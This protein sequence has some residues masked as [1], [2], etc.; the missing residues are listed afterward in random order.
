MMALDLRHNDRFHALPTAIFWGAI[1]SEIYAKPETVAL[2][3]FR[4]AY[5]H[6]SSRTLPC[7]RDYKKN[8]ARCNV[9]DRPQHHRLGQSGRR[10]DSERVRHCATSWVPPA[11]PILSNRQVRTPVLLEHSSRMR[12]P[13]YGQRGTPSV[14]PLAHPERNAWHCGHRS[15]LIV[16]APR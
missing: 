7:T 16:T 4:P 1:N 9:S 5:D 10:Q 15:S 2:R 13:Q 14:M 3:D 6:T 11:S 12:A 8:C